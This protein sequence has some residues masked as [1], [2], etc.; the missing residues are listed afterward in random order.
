MATGTAT[1]GAPIAN[2]LQTQAA[3]ASPVL[4]TPAPSA[5]TV[6][7]S[8]KVNGK[9]HR[10]SIDPARNSV[11]C[12]IPQYYRTARLRRRLQGQ[13]F[14]YMKH[15]KRRESPRCHG[16]NAWRAPDGVQVITR[17][18]GSGFGGKLWPGPHSVFAAACART[19]N[20]PFKLVVSR[21]MMF[22]SVSHRPAIDQ[23]IQL[24][25]DA[26]G[27]F[28]AIQQDYAFGI[29]LATPLGTC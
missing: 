25:A 6:L 9:M 8:L 24:A 23:R 2:A 16:G 29:W 5:S 17:F 11:G 22:V 13:T 3:I 19:L 28:A 10:V 26:S 15:H 18:L 20:R 21:S 1:V 7:V 12:R 4:G 14:P 27:K